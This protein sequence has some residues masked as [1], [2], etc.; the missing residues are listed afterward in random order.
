MHFRPFGDDAEPY[1]TYPQVRRTRYDAVDGTFRRSYYART[2]ELAKQLRADAETPF[3]YILAVNN[4][5]QDGF[6][7]SERP[8]QPEPGH[9]CR[10]TPS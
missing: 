6:G 4:Y 5:L 9:A 10:S 7:Y 3:E 1:V 8:Q 2:W